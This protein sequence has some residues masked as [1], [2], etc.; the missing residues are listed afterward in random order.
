M[1]ADILGVTQSYIRMM[2][3]DGRIKAEKIGHDWLIM[4]K[5]I[6]GIKRQR[7]SKKDTDNGCSTAE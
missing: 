7:H 6:K 3:A 1:A 5:D 4:L 2:I